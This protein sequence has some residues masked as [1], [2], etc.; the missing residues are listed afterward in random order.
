MN[1][2]LLCV[3]VVLLFL[4]VLLVGKTEASGRLPGVSK[5]DVYVYTQIYLWF[6][7]VPSAMINENLEAWNHTLDYRVTVTGI[8]GPVVSVKIQEF[9]DNG[10][11][12]NETGWANVDDGAFDTFRYPMIAANM[13]VNDQLGSL[14]MIGGAWINDS[15][16]KNYADGP[17]EVN[18]VQTTTPFGQTNY[19][20]DRKTGMLVEEDSQDNS[21]TAN[22]TFTVKLAETTVWAAP[23]FPPFAVLPLFAGA[24]LLAAVIVKRQSMTRKKSD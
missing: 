22:S 4:P 14:N 8:S 7:N 19:Y 13:T 18:H 15:S 9:L 21:P 2:K 10:N 11:I 5:G 23:E 24:S 17:R 12:D 3:L 1:K 20:F 6:P 16:V